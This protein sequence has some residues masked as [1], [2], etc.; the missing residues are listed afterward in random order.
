MLN[1]DIK[2]YRR[3]EIKL[4]NQNFR[5]YQT[6]SKLAHDTLSRQKARIC[7]HQ[8]YRYYIPLTWC[9]SRPVDLCNFSALG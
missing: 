3:H 2:T 6:P 5:S 9:I 7:L 4:K 8:N 1:T